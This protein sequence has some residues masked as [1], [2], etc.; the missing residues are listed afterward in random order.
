MKL[1]DIRQIAA[2]R[3]GIDTLNP[4]QCAMAGAHDPVT[5]LI[6]PTGS[7]K[8]LAF[9]IAALMSLGEPCG[10]PQVV[11]IAPGRELVLQIYDVVRV[12]SR[13]YRTVAFY[14]GRSVTDEKN[15][16]AGGVPDIIVSTPGRLVDHINRRRLESGVTLGAL[17]LDEFDKCLELG[18][19]DEMS[20]I[21]RFYGHPRRLMLTSATAMEELPEYIP[22]TRPQ[23]LD[24][25]GGCVSAPRRQMHIMRVISP[26]R[27]KI[28]TLVELLRA[29]CRRGGR[30]MVFVNHRE[31]A[32]RVHGHLRKQGIA[33]GLYHGGLE[34][35]DRERAVELL[36]NG[37]TPVLVSTD[38]AARGLD[39]EGVDSVV[40]Y[41]LPVNEAT[42]IHRNGRTAR[43]D[44]RGTVY[45]ITTEGEAVPEYVEWDNDFYPDASK[46]APDGLRSEMATL[47]FAAGK[48]EKISRGDIVGFLLA[49]VDSLTAGEIGRIALKD[50]YALVAVP[51]GRLGEILGYVSGRKIK[52]KKVRITPLK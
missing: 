27:D 15:S 45:V 36:N 13:G 34:Q 14:G 37:T 46:G 6:A 29:T 22:A 50:H 4:M 18:F 43:Q 40:H 25:T 38:L 11:V 7:G 52:N 44:A 24:F 1:K 9:T 47:Y 31:S 12:M 51:R 10:H 20:R 33:A 8:T 49:N 26:A 32:E 17:V 30:T 39:I 42:W 21:M 2:E 16:L 35:D 41:H 19:G 3:L 48:R 5:M 23:V 28:D